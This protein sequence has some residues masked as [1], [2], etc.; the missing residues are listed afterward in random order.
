MGMERIAATNELSR[1]L[2][3]FWN[4]RELRA[5]DGFP[6]SADEISAIKK[7]VD[8]HLGLFGVGVGGADAKEYF[9][10][11]ARPP[12]VKRLLAYGRA[13]SSRR[14]AGSVGTTQYTAA[15]AARSFV[16]WYE[17]T[18]ARVSQ[19]KLRDGLSKALIDMINCLPAPAP[20]AGPAMLRAPQN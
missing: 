4:D 9:A 2:Y 14:A 10:D 8:V 13:Q 15:S 20:T 7:M 18:E 6:L 17:Q 11:F 3:V 12:S 5:E 1:T 19:M 16:T